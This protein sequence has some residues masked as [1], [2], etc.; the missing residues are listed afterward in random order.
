VHVVD[1]L[2]RFLGK[3]V[4]DLLD[5]GDQT[6]FENLSGDAINF[7]ELF[8]LLRFHVFVGVRKSIQKQ[9]HLLMAGN[10][11]HHEPAYLFAG[12]LHGVSVCKLRQRLQQVSLVLEH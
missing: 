4:D 2:L 10:L 9:D 3:D 8:L 6:F 12:D 5:V 11:S 1:A 7:D